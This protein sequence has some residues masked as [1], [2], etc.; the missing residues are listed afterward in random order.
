MKEEII[1]VGIDIGTSTTQLVFSKITLENLSSGARVPQVKIVDKEIFYRSKIYTTPLINF[2]EIDIEALKKILVDE[3]KASKVPREKIKTGAVIITGETARKTNAREVLKALSGMAGDFVVATAGPDLESIISGKGA[4]AMNFS[5]EKNTSIYN[6]D[7]GGGTTNIS[8]FDQGEVIDTTCLDIGGRLIKFEKTTLKIT[9][10]FKKY[11]KLIKKLGLKSLKV[12]E[13]AEEKELE[14]LCERIAGV[15]LEA[16][17]NIE[18][19]S[20]DYNLFL[21]DKNYKTKSKGEFVSFSGGVADFI[22]TKPKK[23]DYYIYDDIGPLL[24]VCIKKKLEKEKIN[25]IKLGETIRATVVGAGSHTTEISGS[26]ISYTKE[27][28]PIK[29]LPIL[30]INDSDKNFDYSELAKKIE[31]KLDWFKIEDEYQDLA[32]GLSGRKNLK[33]KDIQEISKNIYK[34]MKKFKSLVVILEEDIGKVLGQCLILEFKNMIP[35]VCIDSIKVNDGDFVDIGLPLG[36][37]SVLP[38]I[39]KTLV[40]NY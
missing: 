39:V 15:I 20:E 28:L 23:T 16:I 2:Y 3:Y 13:V 26:T 4:G 9:Y 33:Y 19:K 31:K 29:N 11:E 22:Y 18:S 14:I 7:I 17:V 35:I 25:I 37:G 5:E 8:L 24:G 38:V 32:I 40:L 36:K 10:I 27:M 21:T 34:V 12:G 1:S 30:K 6:L